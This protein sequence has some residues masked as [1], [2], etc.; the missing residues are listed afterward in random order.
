MKVVVLDRD[1]VINQD[2]DNYIKSEDEWLPIAGSIQAIADLCKAGYQ[3]MVATNQS[4]LGR[5][6]FDEYA[7]A[8]MHHKLRSMVEDAGGAVAGIF[9]C[10]HTPEQHCDCRKPGVGLLQQIEREFGCS[11][12][13]CY[14]VG[15]SY[16]DI[17][18]AL[19]FRCIPVLVRTGKGRETEKY[20][21]RKGSSGIPVFENLADAV[22]QLLV[23]HDA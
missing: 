2:S 18:T 22:Q 11:L 10:P 7:L 6:L 12:A 13:G 21:N 14:F 1:G 8:R 3:V 20:I 5:K 15:D 4:G 17:E 16:K 19:A 23:N 9:Y